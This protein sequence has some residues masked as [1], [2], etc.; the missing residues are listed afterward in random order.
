MGTEEMKQDIK[1]WAVTTNSCFPPQKTQ[2]RRQAGAGRA[3]NSFG[4]VSLSAERCPSG[5]RKRPRHSQEEHHISPAWLYSAKW[6]EAWWYRE[7]ETWLGLRFQAHHPYSIFYMA[8][9]RSNYLS[10]GR[11]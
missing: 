8:F 11:F 1:T 2:G 3:P 6:S 5:S 9:W 10:P 7:N 4:C